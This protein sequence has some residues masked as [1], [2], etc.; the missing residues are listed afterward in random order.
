MTLDPRDALLQAHTPV[1]AVPRFGEL[2]PLETVGHRYLV[3][4]AG[5]WLEARRPW[6]YVRAPIARTLFGDY[7]GVHALPF[8][9]LERR[10]E[11]G[12]GSEDLDRVQVLFLH[13]AKRAMPN[14]FAAWAVF[15]DRTRRLEYRPLLAEHASAGGL[16]GI[17]RPRLEDHEHLAIDLHSHGAMPAFFSNT[18]DGDD[19]GEVKLAVVAGRLDGTPQ[20]TTRLCVL[21]LFIG[22]ESAEGELDDDD[23]GGRCRVCGC[24]DQYAC[25]GGCYWIEPDLCSSC[26]PKEPQ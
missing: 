19:A 22:N 9:K 15:N 26:A 13:D 23:A 5:L 4:E 3:D 14:E 16:E 21:G 18:D 11:Y 17:R 7:A 12:F 8:G 6:L 24:T 1:I 25:I 2:A 10:M 20:W